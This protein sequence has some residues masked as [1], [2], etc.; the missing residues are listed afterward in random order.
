MNPPIVLDI[1]GSLHGLEDTQ[2]IDLSDWQEAIRFGCSWSTWKRFRS[3]LNERLPASYGPV[4]M[5]SGDFHH[6]SHLLLDRISHSEPFDVV[7]LDNHP[8]NMRFPFGIHCGS[9][10]VH[11]AR[12][13][14]IRC[15]HILGITS[16]DVSWRHAWENHLLPIAQGRI[17]YWTTGVNVQWV[18]PFGLAKSIASFKNV[19]VLINQFIAEREKQIPGAVYLSID[20]DVFS[21]NVVRTNWDQGCFD[22]DNVRQLIQAFKGK[23]IGSDI[24]GEVSVHHFRTSWKRWLSAM[25]RQPTISAEALAKWQTQHTVVNRQLLT[26]LKD[27]EK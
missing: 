15:V 24:T 8:D 1:D 14:Q 19:Q 12:L 10:V 18:N 9:W 22:L 7:V 13:P 23:L 26:W 4:C 5:G 6:I 25:D 27:V 17:R 11:A 16:A 20:K 2:T 21:T 3:L